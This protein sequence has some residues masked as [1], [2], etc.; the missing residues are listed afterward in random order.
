MI[1]RIALLCSLL[2]ATPLG[3]KELGESCE[4][5]TPKDGFVALRDA[6]SREGKLIARMDPKGA[7]IPRT[8][9]R[10]WQR[11]KWMKVS[12]WRPGIE[13]D[14]AVKSGPVGWISR[15]LISG[16]G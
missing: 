14:A 13:F 4:L 7:V 2:L 5:E 15:S 10:D 9:H 6:P 1:A 12:Y 3:A 8:D 11:D 16:C